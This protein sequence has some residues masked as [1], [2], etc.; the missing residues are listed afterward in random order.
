MADIAQKA[1]GL[2]AKTDEELVS[3]LV[4][5]IRLTAEHL[6]E[7][8]S[9]VYEL[10]RRGKDLSYLRLAMIHHLRR[11]ACGQLLPEVVVRF[12]GAPRL[13]SLISNLPLDDQKRMSDGEM[14]KLLVY[15][16]SG[17]KTH[18]MADPLAMTQSQARQVLAKDHIRTESEQSL[19]LDQW[20]AKKRFN[21]P[22]RIGELKI[23]KE[24]GGVVVGR[25]FIALTDLQAAVAVLRS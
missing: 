3:G 2:H 8:A 9:Y 19:I 14:L 21:P 25:R 1:E 5:R 4:K 24:R 10:E 16:A 11:I 7:L 22:D 6:V 20:I 23:D 12:A 13:M 15:T 17:E 18:R